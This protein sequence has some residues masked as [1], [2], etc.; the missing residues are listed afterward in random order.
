M[1]DISKL[2]DYRKKFKRYYGIDFSN[3]YA[4]HH[5]DF[6]RSNNDISNLMILPKRLHSRYHF[7][8]SAMRSANGGDGPEFTVNG[9]I[10]SMNRQ[11]WYLS[12]MDNFAEVMMECAVWGDYK[13]YLDG[14]LPN[15]HGIDLD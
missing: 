14:F 13:L 3:K 9:R 6:D 2:K 10:Q 15:I 1:K 7:C 12:T 11:S 8:I 4:I 5:I